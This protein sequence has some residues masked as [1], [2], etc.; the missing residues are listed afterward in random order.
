MRELYEAFLN[1][2]KEEKS[3]KIFG[4]GK[5]AKTL[6]YLF[7]KNYIIVDSFVVT[8]TEV[9]PH[10][11]LHRPVIGLDSLKPQELSGIVVG[12]EKKEDMKNTTNF[13]LS[14]QVK[15]IIMVSP[16][17]VND[18]YC[19]F[20][21]DQDSVEN[22]CDALDKR[23]DVIVYINDIEGEMIA[24]YLSENG[25]E[26]ESICTDREVL[27]LEVDIPVIN[28]KQI[29]SKS[30]ESTIVLTMNSTFRQ[31]KFI[32]KL[33]NSGFEN[34]IL[35]PDKLLKQMKSEDKKL[36]WERIGAG[37]HFVDN[38]NIEKNFYAVQKE[39]EQ[40]IYRWRIPI[41]DKKLCRKESLEVIR[42]GKMV[43]DYEKQFPGFAY[44]PYREVA[45]REIQNKDINIEVYLVKCHKDKKS[46]LAPL[47]DWII[48]IQAGKALTDMQIASVRDDEGENISRKNGDYS[49]GTAIYWI[50]KNTSGQ[51]Y[52]GLFHYRRQ[53]ALGK[54]SLKKLEEYDIFLT[55][56]TYIPKGIKETFCERF[57]LEYDW[58]LMM[59]YIKEYDSSYYE[60][61][62]KYEKEK[63]Y[64]SCNIFIMRRKY[65]DEM[66]SFIFGVLEKV[67]SYYRNISMVRKD[68]YLGFL[69]ENLLSIYVMH[70]SGRLKAAYTDMKFY[71]PLEEE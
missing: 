4:A 39:Q 60:T 21:I 38:A 53:M 11:L 42:S 47:P 70:N 28:Y 15:N 32:T 67:D 16:S 29:T 37:F 35:I 58:D 7:D 52:I 43:E 23:K 51:D 17:I 45:L 2:V 46:E 66:C 26:I 59:H 41:W 44:L 69:V 68:R 36:M 13:L 57:V 63:C 9:N 8:D 34:I 64:F 65:F 12:V 61:A 3:V 33:R 27:D 25:V 71:Y 30:T 24:R 1:R 49:E 14:R 62:L 31:R 22:L 18:I 50:W 40:K 55:L 20:V 54:D 19:N 5:F 6:C 10:E 56:P 48:P